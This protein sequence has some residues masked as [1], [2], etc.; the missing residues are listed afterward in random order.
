MADDGTFDPRAADRAIAAIPRPGM[1][2]LVV[3]GGVAGLVGGL[4]A[5]HHWMANLDWGLAAH[6]A[7]EQHASRIPSR[8][9][10]ADPPPSP[11]AKAPPQTPPPPAAAPLPPADQPR[12]VQVAAGSVKSPRKIG[13]SVSYQPRENP[14]L[15]EGRTVNPAP[16]CTLLPGQDIKASLVDRVSSEVPGDVTARVTEP[17]YAEAAGP[18]TG[19]CSRSAPS[20]SA[21]T[22]RPASSRA[23][24]GSISPGSTRSF[25]V[26]ARS[27][28][29]TPSGRM[30]AA[31]RASRARSTCTG[32]TCG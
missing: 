28:S 24:G 5:L 21:A 14:D 11:E 2:F 20:W 16:A 27:G 15:I 29:A 19:R 17:V 4:A 8:V 13:Y 10:A 1:P 6:A 9:A 18:A 32:A 30:P 23:A 12:P 31:R 22:S 25:R 7:P 26:D 3:A